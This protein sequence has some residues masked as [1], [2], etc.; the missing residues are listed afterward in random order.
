MATATS[1]LGIWPLQPDTRLPPG[2]TARDLNTVVHSPLSQ[3]KRE[4]S[5]YGPLTGWIAFT[6]FS[7]PTLSGLTNT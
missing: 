6:S 7:L 4:I 1:P 5:G 3:G 2:T